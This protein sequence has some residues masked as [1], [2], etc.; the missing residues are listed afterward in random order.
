MFAKFIASCILLVT[1][2]R[3]PLLKSNQFDVH[4]ISNSLSLFY[5]KN[6]QE[7][8]FL[9]FDRE[10]YAQGRTI[11]YKGWL[12]SLGKLSVISRILYVEFAD[13]S[14]IILSRQ[15]LPVEDGA[16]VGSFKIPFEFPDGQYRV[17]GYTAWMMNFDQR[18]YFEKT[19]L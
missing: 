19:I 2:G 6:P 4:R 3:L 12:T 8:V 7:K 17:R 14:G 18:F 16:A 13:S 9:Q 15:T 11:W 10:D 1:A 5:Q